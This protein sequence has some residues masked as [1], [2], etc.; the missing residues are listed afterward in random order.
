VSAHFHEVASLHIG[1]IYKHVTIDRD[2]IKSVFAGIRW[3]EME[4]S[5]LDEIQRWRK[6]RGRMGVKNQAKQ[7]FSYQAL[8]DGVSWEDMDEG[9]RNPTQS[10][11]SP[12][13]PTGQPIAKSLPPVYG[14]SK[15]DRHTWKA[16]A[17]SN[18]TNVTLC[19]TW[20][21]IDRDSR[22]HTHN[23]LHNG[24]AHQLFPH[25]ETIRV[26]PFPSAHSNIT[27][28]C[29]AEEHCPFIQDIAPK[30]LVHRNVTLT[31][32]E[33]TSEPV[34]ELVLFLPDRKWPEDSEFS[35]AVAYLE[36]RLAKAGSKII[37][38]VFGPPLADKNRPER[39]IQYGDIFRPEDRPSSYIGLERLMDIIRSACAQSTM[40]H[41]YG[42]EK[43]RVP[44][45]EDDWFGE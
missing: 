2:T 30:K 12:R 21:T 17:L 5:W 34:D 29:S 16:Y 7:A 36:D 43:V 19:D 18:C 14:P 22:Y 27:T 15:A 45:D 25:V 24:K 1:K 26:I 39:H 6:G 11:I 41:I 4:E 35:H 42:L 40:T 23:V 44:K 37:K 32:F 13:T 31:G 20:A 33:L 38:L 3:D 10:Y 8:F 9:W 28:L